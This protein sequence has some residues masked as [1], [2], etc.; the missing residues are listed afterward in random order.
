MSEDVTNEPQTHRS[1]VE[2]KPPSI[3]TIANFA[4]KEVKGLVKDIAWDQIV[5]ASSLFVVE[6]KK[7][8]GINEALV[9][10]VGDLLF[11]PFRLDRNLTPEVIR[12]DQKENNARIQHNFSHAI[13]YAGRK[14]ADPQYTSTIYSVIGTIDKLAN[15]SVKGSSELQIFWNG[16]KAEVA[17]IRALIRNGYKVE[18]PDYNQDPF[19]ITRR[20]N[21]VL[22]WDVLNGVDFIA[23]KEGERL[24][25]IDAKGRSKNEYG[26]VRAIAEVMQAPLIDA[27]IPTSIKESHG[28]YFDKGLVRRLRITVPTDR[29]FLSVFTPD[30]ENKRRSINKF[31]VSALEG[32]II[33][34]ID[35]VYTKKTTRVA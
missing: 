21:E 13:L 34:R 4:V 31:G 9:E 2:L 27:Y 30:D 26:E 7:R 25:L 3:A 5:K 32:D 18:L 24:L 12:E 16:L 15:S 11:G 29:K 20:D 35:S 19:E 8:P 33:S 23:Y 6:M 17:I 28:E 22:Q 14:E 10:G 1:I